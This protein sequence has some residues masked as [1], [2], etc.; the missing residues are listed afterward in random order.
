MKVLVT[1][2]VPHTMTQKAEKPLPSASQSSP[3]SPP[4]FI[5]IIPL[6]EHTLCPPMPLRLPDGQEL[7]MVSVISFTH[8]RKRNS[9]TDVVTNFS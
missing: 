6:S 3:L 5:H 4:F 1:L 2:C 7:P 8:A 9:I